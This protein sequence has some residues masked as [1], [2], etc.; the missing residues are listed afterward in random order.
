M[1]VPLLLVFGLFPEFN[2]F[3]VAESFTFDVKAYEGAYGLPSVEASCAGVDVEKLQMSVVL[4]PEDMAVTT[5]EEVRWIGG[6][7]C[8]YASVVVAGMTADVLDE[9]V[10]LFAAQTQNLGK[11]AA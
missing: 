7:A 11:H 1:F 3:K 2:N 10:G 9:D 8:A 4:Y 5:D 6:K